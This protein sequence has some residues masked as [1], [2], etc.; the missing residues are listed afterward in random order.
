MGLDSDFEDKKVEPVISGLATPNGLADKELVT[1]G[2]TLEH[3]TTNASDSMNRMTVNPMV[4]Y[5]SV[6]DYRT[7]PKTRKVSAVRDFP[8]AFRKFDEEHTSQKK[9]MVTFDALQSE[10]GEQELL[11]VPSKETVRK[12]GADLE[13]SEG[14]VATLRA[15]DWEEK[16]EYIVPLAIREQNHG[17]VMSQT[18]AAEKPKLE[19]N[20][21]GESFLVQLEAPKPAKQN[22]TQDRGYLQLNHKITSMKMYPVYKKRKVSAVRSFPAAFDLIHAENKGKGLI[23]HEHIKEEQDVGPDSSLVKKS[24]I[25]KIS[26]KQE[27]VESF[28]EQHL[29]SKDPEHRIIVQALIA[30]PHC[31]WSSNKSQASNKKK[32]REKKKGI[33]KQEG[34]AR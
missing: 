7:L 14:G 17:E 15:S 19:N 32:C 20:R 22:I 10:S 4:G 28:P 24:V 2:G 21:A 27:I 13:D 26:I 33:Q 30:A 25:P 5:G 12:M 9:A 23:K 8:L 31:P 1:H 16:A 29:G 11:N 18:D 3:E 6:R 34:I